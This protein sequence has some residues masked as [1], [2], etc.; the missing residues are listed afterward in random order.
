[1]VMEIHYDF[2]LDNDGRAFGEECLRIL[3]AV[4]GTGSLRKAAAEANLS[5]CT[6]FKIV[7]ESEERLGFTLIERR[8]GGSSGGGSRLTSEARELM[9]RY[10]LFSDEMRK[11]VLHMEGIV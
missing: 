7:T 3:E 6:V 5:Y 2:W 8:I 11:I 4:D 9:A 10:R 1:M